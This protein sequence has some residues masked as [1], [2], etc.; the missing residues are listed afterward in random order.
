[1]RAG[2]RAHGV[3]AGPARDEHE[4]H[5]GPHLAGE[6]GDPQEPRGGLVAAQPLLPQE[7]QVAEAQRHRG[8]PTP[9]AKN[10]SPA[11]HLGIRTPRAPRFPA[12][13]RLPDVDQNATSFYKEGPVGDPS[14]AA[15]RLAPS[16][17]LG[18]YE[19]LAAVG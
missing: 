12:N 5:L 10:H 13:D 6:D 11:P 2:E 18:P 14:A 4:L 15:Q 17:R 9:L 7:L 19:V 3:E 8:P 1:M 16:T